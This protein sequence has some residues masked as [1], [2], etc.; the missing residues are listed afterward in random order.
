M[1]YEVNL[2]GYV[3]TLQGFPSIFKSIS[4]EASSQV[5]YTQPMLYCSLFIQHDEKGLSSSHSHG[6]IGLQ[7]LTYACVAPNSYIKA[8]TPNVM[9]LET[10]I[11]GGN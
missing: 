1:K 8:L 7:L 4:A 10:G 9:V 11:L 5:G 3:E 6:P 2:K